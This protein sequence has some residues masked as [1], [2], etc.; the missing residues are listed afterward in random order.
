[1]HSSSDDADLNNICEELQIQHR[2]VKPVR[3]NQLYKSL[4][5]LRC[6][7]KEIQDIKNFKD[8]DV[9]ETIA[10]TQSKPVKVLI[11][12]DHKVNMALCKI[13]VKEII[14]GAIIIEAVNGVQAI[15]LY[16]EELPSI[17]LMDIQM[18]EMNGYDA[19]NEIRKGGSKVPI[20]ALTAGTVAGE[21]ERCL[22][23]GMD[24]Y[25]SKPFVKDTMQKAIYQWLKN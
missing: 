15:Q 8:K 9:K 14:P 19:C 24:D 17:I 21:K 12:E 13:F 16:K 10:V 11:V 25:I 6:P 3:I 7:Q 23:A 2:L 20:I 5:Q 4:S 18:P 22:A 1:M